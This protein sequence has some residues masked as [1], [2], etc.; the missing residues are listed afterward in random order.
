MDLDDDEDDDPDYT[1][2]F[3][4]SRKKIWGRRLYIFA[5]PDSIEYGFFGIMST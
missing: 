1:G 4:R 3:Y 5:Q 2:A